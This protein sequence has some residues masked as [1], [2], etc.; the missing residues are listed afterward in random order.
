MVHITGATLPP[1]SASRSRISE[2][3]PCSHTSCIGDCQDTMQLYALKSG[4][5]LAHINSWCPS[6]TAM[7]YVNNTQIMGI[8]AK[9]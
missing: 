5:V 8:F 3:D 1:C 4:I 2:T 7:P 6:H 9:L